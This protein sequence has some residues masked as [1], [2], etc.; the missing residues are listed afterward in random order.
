MSMLKWTQMAR[1]QMWAEC[2]G[3]EDLGSRG[4]TVVA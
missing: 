2:L 3:M 1:L 4:Y